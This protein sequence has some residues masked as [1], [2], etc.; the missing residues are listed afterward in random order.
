MS[1]YDNIRLAYAGLTDHDLD[2]KVRL[3]SSSKVGIA[4]IANDIVIENGGS[5][6]FHNINLQIDLGH[7]KIYGSA[8]LYKP[9][10]LNI[11]TGESEIGMPPNPGRVDVSASVSHEITNLLQTAV[12]SFPLRDKT[13]ALKAAHR[14]DLSYYL[15]EEG[16][17]LDVKLEN[18]DIVI[19]SLS[20]KKI[21]YHDVTLAVKIRAYY[22]D[23]EVN[24]I[25]ESE[26]VLL[27]RIKATLKTPI[28]HV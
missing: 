6:L 21:M 11:T 16:P 2:M 8:D 19:P 17:S 7:Q 10:Y 5:T 20:K 3:A 12:L 25:Y 24:R 28:I 18:D 14:G 23:E 9:R 1:T 22:L 27:H 15:Q 13:D 26:P 4:G